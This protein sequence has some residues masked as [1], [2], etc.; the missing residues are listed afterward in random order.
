MSCKLQNSKKKKN[1][2]TF[3]VYTNIATRVF[4]PIRRTNATPSPLRFD[5]S[6]YAPAT[7]LSQ[8]LNSHIIEDD[9]TC[10]VLCNSSI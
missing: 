5:Y 6:S 8:L 7:V 4:E 9:N 1:L 2:P 10:S 3:C